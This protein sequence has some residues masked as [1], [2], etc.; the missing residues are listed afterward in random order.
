MTFSASLA[1]AE[2]AHF[3]MLT[4]D[5]AGLISVAINATDLAADLPCVGHRVEYHGRL[6]RGITWLG[7]DY[8][9][10]VSDCRRVPG[11]G[12]VRQTP[13]AVETVLGFHY[14]QSRRHSSWS[15]RA[16]EASE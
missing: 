14:L 4:H 6:E 11:P 5:A 7:F 16:L 8:N 10:L 13:I 12:E 3:G 1:D 9:L 2:S 15:E